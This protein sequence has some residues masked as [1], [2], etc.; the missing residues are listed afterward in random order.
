MVLQASQ[1]CT[2]SITRHSLTTW[3]RWGSA[4]RK[5]VLNRFMEILVKVREGQERR[6]NVTVPLLEAVFPQQS[7]KVHIPSLFQGT[8]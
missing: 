1:N 4:S 3:I 7:G 6:K 5:D 8:Q 2:G